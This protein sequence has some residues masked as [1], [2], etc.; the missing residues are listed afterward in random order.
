[1]SDFILFKFETDED[2]KNRDLQ[3]KRNSTI[4]EGL[5]SF[6]SATNSVMTLE[7]DKIVFWN[8]SKMLNSPK[9]LDK[10][11]GEHF[12]SSVQN[13]RIKV[14]DTGNILGGRKIIIF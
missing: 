11:V 10:K 12:N 13:V 14:N 6:L 4:R 2:S 5:L 1:M 8:K 3:I 9:F 7:L